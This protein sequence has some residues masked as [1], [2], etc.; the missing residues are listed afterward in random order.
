MVGMTKRSKAQLEERAEIDRFWKAAGL[1]PAPYQEKRAMILA[2]SQT[3]T[4]Q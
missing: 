1:K 3:Q 4:K 2:L